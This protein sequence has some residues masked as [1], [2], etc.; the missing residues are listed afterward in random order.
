MK[1]NAF[2]FGWIMMLVV[3]IQRALVSIMMFVEGK[4]PDANILYGVHVIAILFITLNSFRK[5]EAWSWWCLLLVGGIPPA[6]CLAV[7]GLNIWVI[8]SW[9]LFL[10]AIFFPVKGFFP[11]K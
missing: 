6:Y 10:P 5:K 2:K 8:V 7:H 4:N 9:I 11:G 1:W 3:G